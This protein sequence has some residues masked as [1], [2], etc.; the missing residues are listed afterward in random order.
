LQDLPTIPTNNNQLTNGEGYLKSSDLPPDS[1]LVLGETSGAAYRGD[2]GKVAYD[3]SQSS[4]APSNAERNVNPD[5]DANSGD[6]EIL[7]KPNLLDTA[8]QNLSLGVSVDLDDIQ[9][10]QIHNTE[11]IVKGTNTLTYNIKT[12]IADPFVVHFIT[13]GGYLKFNEGAGVTIKS[14]SSTNSVGSR[15]MAKLV[16]EKGAEEFQLIV[17]PITA[18]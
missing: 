16:K 14:N 18:L 15:A 4:H 8:T 2:R 7:N 1:G 13:D 11:R 3:H 17:T 5:W 6:A 9:A 10:K 12:G